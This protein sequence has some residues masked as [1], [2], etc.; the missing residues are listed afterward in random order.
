LSGKSERNWTR[1]YLGLGANLD[2]RRAQLE[3]A[4]EQL[5]AD[6]DIRLVRHTGFAE[7][8]PWGVAD[9]PRF[10]NAVAEIETGLPPG[11]LLARLK[12]IERALGRGSSETRRW[13]PR[14]IDLDILLYGDLVH[15]DDL[16]VIPHPRLVER[17]FVIE[18]LVELDP[19][20]RHP[21]TGLTL[22]KHLD[23]L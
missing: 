1:V 21:K 9:Q 14:E 19:L 17:A 4:L 23:D 11:E 12:E 13:G 22:A 8:R 7:T 16:L 3:R 5:A 15:E 2:D 18:Q 10:L 6:P 20:L